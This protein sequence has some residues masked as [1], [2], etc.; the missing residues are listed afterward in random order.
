M[1]LII[2]WLAAGVI[3]Y[4]YLGYPVL[5]RLLALKRPSVV[6]ATDIH[7]KV[8]VIIAAFNEEK[9]IRAKLDSIL[10]SDYPVDRLSVIV[11]SDCSTDQTDSIVDSCEDKRVQLLRVERRLGK[12]NVQN[13]CAARASV[14]GGDPPALPG[15]HPEFDSSGN[16]MR[17]SQS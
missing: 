14:N 1:A 3:L 16:G 10:A 11:G 8:T 6:K 12:T 13:A 4:T 2:F 9:S 17:N 5:M 7:P 15:R